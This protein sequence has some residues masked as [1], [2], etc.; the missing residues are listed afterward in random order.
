MVDK[1]DL[2]DAILKT[3]IVDYAARSITI[4]LDCFERQED[5]E[6]QAAVIIFDG[7]DSLSQLTDLKEL[8]GHTFAGHVSY[9]KPSDSYGTTYIYLVV[10]SIAITAEKVHFKFEK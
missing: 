8:E 6:K 9:W 4:R 2:H 7:V 5:R 1:I 3:M 10:G